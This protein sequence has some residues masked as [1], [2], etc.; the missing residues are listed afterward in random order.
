MLAPHTL[1]EYALIADGER[2]ALVGPRG[3][4]AWMCFPGWADDARRGGGCVPA[5]R[6][7]AQSGVARTRRRDRRVPCLR[8]QPISVR[9]A[10]PAR[11]GV[12]CAA[13]PAPR[14]PAA[15]VRARA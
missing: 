5:V 10:G 13:A 14:Q 2:G 7:R 8:A 4:I 6:F 3:E 1:R 15:A 12:R 11:R 9:A